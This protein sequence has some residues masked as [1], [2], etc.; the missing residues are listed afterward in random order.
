M[1]L[2]CCLPLYHGFASVNM[3]IQRVYIFAIC[4]VYKQL[5]LELI[6]FLKLNSLAFLFSSAK[7]TECLVQTAVMGL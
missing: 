1:Y 5:V 4:Y 2:Y 3:T 6:L 7:V